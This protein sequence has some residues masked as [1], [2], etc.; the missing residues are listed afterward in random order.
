MLF[1]AVFYIIL[2][3]CLAVLLVIA[4]ITAISRQ[5][6][7]WDDAERDESARADSAHRTNKARRAQSKQ[8]RRKRH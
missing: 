6:R 4:G 5:R 8:A 2:F 3:S 1:W 7:R